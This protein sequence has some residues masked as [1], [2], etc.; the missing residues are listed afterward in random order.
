MRTLSIRLITG[1]ILPAFHHPI[2][3]ASETAML[4]C[5]SKGRL[6]VGFGRAYLPYEFAAF[7]VDLD[8][9]RE[10]YTSTILAVID[11]WTKSKVAAKTKFF[12]LRE[13]HNFAKIS[14]GTTPPVWG[15]AVNF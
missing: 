10:K 7:G 4:D 9:S 6:E 15:A 13:C 5:I 8:D 12:Q 3:I 1:C 2:Q 14:A 11:L